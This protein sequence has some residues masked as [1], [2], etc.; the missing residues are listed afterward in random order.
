MSN[1]TWLT[2][3]TKQTI[4]VRSTSSETM[5]VYV[6]LPN[7]Y[8]PIYEADYKGDGMFGGWDAYVLLAYLNFTTEQ[9]EPLTEDEKRILGFHLHTGY[10]YVDDDG[11]Q[12]C[13]ASQST[14]RV[15]SLLGIEEAIFYDSL[16]DVL[17]V[18]GSSMRVS[19]HIT[20]RN[21]KHDPFNV[22]FPLKFSFSKD[23]VY[24]N[25]PASE[26]I[27]HQY[28][29]EIMEL[30]PTLSDFDNLLVSN[31]LKAKDRE[32]ESSLFREILC[33]AIKLIPNSRLLHFTENAIVNMANF[34]DDSES[35]LGI[36]DELRA[37]AKCLVSR[38]DE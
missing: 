31:I 4:L 11:F 19:Y 26:V 38:H 37:M 29:S 33:D 8:D 22:K 34:V 5:P 23:S 10:R 24:E 13:L 7:G 16:D 15:K 2:A 6:L 36:D 32:D 3:D 30:P 18:Q 14:P 12:Y 17:S 28:V 25:L 27:Q 9:L 20:L 35:I 21:L 1:F